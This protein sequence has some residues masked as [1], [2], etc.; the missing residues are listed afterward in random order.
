[1]SPVQIGPSTNEISKLDMLLLNYNN[2]I[3]AGEIEADRFYPATPNY[4][5][6]VK[7]ETKYFSDEEY[8]QLVEESGRKAS[9]SLLRKNLNW[10][11]P[12]EEDIEKIRSALR[13]FRASVKRKILRA[14]Q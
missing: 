9:E 3:D 13:R 14:K 5:Y 4:W 11:K 10:E 12:T 7:G 8:E 2:R 1:M 6:T